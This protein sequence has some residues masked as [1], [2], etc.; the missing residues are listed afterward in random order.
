M[1][2]SAEFPAM[3]SNNLWSY[4]SRIIQDSNAALQMGK[5]CHQKLTWLASWLLQDESLPMQMCSLA[6]FTRTGV[7][8]GGSLWQLNHTPVIVMR[9]P[10]VWLLHLLI[11]QLA[12]IIEHNN[13]I[14]DQFARAPMQICCN[15]H[16]GVLLAFGSYEAI[17]KRSVRLLISRLHNNSR[18]RS[19]QLTNPRSFYLVN[20]W[21]FELSHSLF[22]LEKDPTLS[23]TPLT[24]LTWLLELSH[25]CPR[26]RPFQIYLLII[27]YT[28]IYLFI[29]F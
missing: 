24:L 4:Q 9:R 17:F 29:Y 25:S 13:S 18:R 3:D 21:S 26:R 12:F 6:P 28:F 14:Q 10:G 20:Q 7:T 5:G 19:Q 16:S 1:H 8:A 27:S 11:S 2:L 23:K 15:A 22:S